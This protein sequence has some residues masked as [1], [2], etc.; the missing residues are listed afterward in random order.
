MASLAGAKNWVTNPSFEIDLG[1]WDS[2][3]VT[4]FIRVDTE[5][6]VGDY[7]AKATMSGSPAYI[8]LSNT[9]RVHVETQDEVAY[10]IRI[11]SE[12]S[13][14]YAFI[15]TVFYNSGG[16]VTHTISH[17][18]V[19]LSTGW[20]TLKAFDTA[21]AGDVETNL[22]VHYGTGLV[23]GEHL[24]F[25]GCEIRRNEQLDTYI[26]GDQGSIYDWSGTAHDSTSLR[27]D[28]IEKVSIGTGGVIHMSAELYRSNKNGDR[29]ENISEDLIEGEVTFSADAEVHM[30]FTAKIRDITELS[31]YEDYV[32]PVLRL[33]Y[34]GGSVTEEQ[35][36]HYIVVPA[37]RRYSQTS[38]EG[39]VDGRGLEWL[40]TMDEY[41]KGYSISAGN[42]FS[43]EV[44]NCLR[45]ADIRKFNI[46]NSGKTV[47]KKRTWDPGTKRI[48]VINDLLDSAGYHPIHMARDGRLTSFK[49]PNVKHAEPAV[50]YDTGSRSDIVGVVT[51]TPDME[52]FANRM[53]VLAEDAERDTI[54]VIQRN[55]NQA[56]PVSIPRLGFTKTKTH[57]SKNLNNEA[58]ARELCSRMLERAA[59]HL[60]KLEIETV[61]DPTR[62]P[63][64]VYTLRIQQDS[65]QYI[66]F[67]NYACTGWTL[68]FSP[69]QGSMKHTVERLEIYE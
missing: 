28:I 17:P 46:P 26:D 14:H 4:N 33:Q 59:R 68:G 57:T 40:L 62:N 32:I 24:W 52:N 58:D 64:E 7:S 50:M 60:V 65:D 6:W 53:V 41:S 48:K 23:N 8:T 10:A 37:A 15:E 49:I 27:A 61:P 9:N 43:L 38:T 63:Y 55:D 44:R 11:H 20:T 45:Q 1:G 2:T 31:A 67:G 66:A 5:E 21:V 47:P 56:S 18:E 39:T 3:G 13:S 29:L 69:G 12:S 54:R 30:N 19:Q 34:A 51:E 42:D 22:R 16:T 25:D 35:V 36:G